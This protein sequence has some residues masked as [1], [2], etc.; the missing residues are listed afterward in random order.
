VVSRFS[1]PPS[2]T[3]LAQVRIIAR[4]PAT[5]GTKCWSLAASV[6]RSGTGSVSAEATQNPAALVSAGD[7]VGM[8]ACTIAMFSDATDLGVQLTGPAATTINWAVWLD[9]LMVTD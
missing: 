6:K 7:T 2:T 3:V 4:N 9:A 8:S 5:G 1:V